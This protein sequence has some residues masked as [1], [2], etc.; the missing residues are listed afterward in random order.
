M[1]LA[2]ADG[3]GKRIIPTER[4]QA[5]H[6]QSLALM[7]SSLRTNQVF[8]ASRS[9]MRDSCHI[10]NFIQEI[11]QISGSTYQLA[12]RDRNSGSIDVCNSNCLDVVFLRPPDAVFDTLLS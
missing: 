1:N 4:I 8:C 2:E 9:E 5:N 11:T 3:T 10:I 6:I 12:K 7:F